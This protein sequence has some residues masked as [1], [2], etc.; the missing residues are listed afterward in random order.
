MS[1]EFICTVEWE[2]N[3]A[4]TI[5]LS[6][7]CFALPL[8]VTIVSYASVM[9]VACHQAH[10]TLPVTVGEIEVALQVTPHYS[11]SILDVRATRKPIW[12][13]DCFPDNII[14]G[15]TTAPIS[16]NGNFLKYYLN[17]LELTK[18]NV[19]LTENAIKLDASTIHRNGVKLDFSEKEAKVPF[20]N[21]AMSKKMSFLD[22]VKRK[23]RKNSIVPGNSLQKTRNNSTISRVD[24]VIFREDPNLYRL[25]SA[26]TSEELCGHEMGIISEENEE[27]GTR[28]NQTSLGDLARQREW[29]AVK[30]KNNKQ[31][32]ERSEAVLQRR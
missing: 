22:L 23:K 27:H 10:E 2:Y 32:K 26:W 1:Y 21:R 8:I 13:T 28:Q 3:K 31:N 24:P 4:Y 29:M 5:F 16:S 30:M 14:K 18:D 7:T 19:I 17:D 15:E 12:Q 6:V 20:S 25:R 11:P 9:K